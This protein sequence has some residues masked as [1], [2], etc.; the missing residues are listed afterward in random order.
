M[1]D[2]FAQLDG[3]THRFTIACPQLDAIHRP[4]P[5]AHRI[6]RGQYALA[7]KR[8][9][10]LMST[11]PQRRD[12]LLQVATKTA[13]KSEAFGALVALLEAVSEEVFQNTLRGVFCPSDQPHIVQWPKARDVVENEGEAP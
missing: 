5:W 2:E 9:K 1:W 12:I 6:A 11:F 8:Y 3:L 4:F 7:L 13:G 10:V